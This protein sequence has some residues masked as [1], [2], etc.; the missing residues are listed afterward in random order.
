MNYLITGGCGFIGVNLVKRLLK[1]ED[2]NIRIIDNLSVGLLK[3]LNTVCNSLSEKRVQFIEGDIRDELLAMEV[4]KDIDIIIHLAAN[5]GVPVSV[6]FPREDCIANILGTLNYL[7]GARYN[8]VKRFIFAS[9][10]AVP[11]DHIPPYHEKLFARPIAPYGA[12]KAAAESYCH[13][14]NATYGVETVALRFSNV[15]GPF[16][17]NKKAQLISHFIQA[18]IDKNPLIIFGDGTQTRDFCFVDDL[19]DA[20]ELSISTPNIG[21]HVF[22]IA[23][24]IETKVQTIT[25]VIVDIFNKRYGIEDIEVCYANERYGDVKQNFSDTTKAK[26]LLNW[27]NKVFIEQGIYKTIEWF[28]KLIN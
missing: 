14:Y 4:C 20:I 28:V 7:E 27:E 21:G 8:K 17:N 24:N 16:S 9:S 13:V 10:S 23:T 22:Q 18:V 12:S 11:G 15:Y 19:I 26:K 6:E 25:D 1:N 3:N 5:T 2:N